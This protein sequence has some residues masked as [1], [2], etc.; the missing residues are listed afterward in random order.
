MDNGAVGDIVSSV[1]LRLFAM[2]QVDVNFG[3][4]KFYHAAKGIGAI[5][6]TMLSAGASK[7]N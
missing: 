7:P 1:E 3:I 4:V 2:T 6:R 5:D